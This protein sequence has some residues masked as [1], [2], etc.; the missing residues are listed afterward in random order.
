V[1]LEADLDE[2]ARRRHE[3]LVRRG[4]AVSFA[5]VRE[6]LAAR[7]KRDLEREVA[8][9]RCADDAVRIDTTRLTIPAAVEAVLD[10]VEQHGGG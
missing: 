7:D 9:L 1:Y 4:E 5:R 8:P 2:R 6:A 3:E 10:L